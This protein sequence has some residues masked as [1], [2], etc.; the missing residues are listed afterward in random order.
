ME[1]QTKDEATKT[2]V[3]EVQTKAETVEM[4]EVVVHTKA[5]KAMDHILYV[6]TQDAA[7]QV[8]V[9]ELHETEEV[10][11]LNIEASRWKHH[12]NQL[13]KGMISLTKHKNSIQEL[14]EQWAEEIFFQKIRWE[15]MRENLKDLKKYQSMEKNKEQMLPLTHE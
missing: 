9:A 7:T 2:H 13:E 11:L 15:E 4:K 1:V 10:I 3:I 14:R 8:E 5:E 6:E 12:A